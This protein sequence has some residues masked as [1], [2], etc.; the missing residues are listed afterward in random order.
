LAVK[1]SVTARALATND[2]GPLNSP[3]ERGPGPVSEKLTGASDV[4][5]KR[6]LSKVP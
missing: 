2:F 1:H 3:Y 5:V 4:V 6:Q